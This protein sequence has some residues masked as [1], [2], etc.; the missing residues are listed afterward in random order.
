MMNRMLQMGMP[1]MSGGQ[2]GPPGYPSG[3]YPGGG[4]QGMAG[5]YASGFQRLMQRFPQF[6]QQ[7]GQ[8]G[9]QM[10]PQARTTMGG[11]QQQ[12]Q[13]QQGGPGQP[14]GSAY[15]G[16]FPTTYQGY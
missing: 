4:W 12:A 11:Y 1:D 10:P 7:L 13:P 15:S 9:F 2:G 5:G 14:T 8:G 16:T 3:G 6:G